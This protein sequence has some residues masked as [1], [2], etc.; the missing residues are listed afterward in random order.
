MATN[1]IGLL[2]SGCFGCTLLA[3]LP[4]CLS[5]RF[6]FT[7][8]RGL[9]LVCNDIIY[10]YR[11]GRDGLS[12]ESNLSAPGMKHETSIIHPP[13]KC[14]C[15]PA[16]GIIGFPLSSSQL[17]HTPVAFPALPVYPFAIIFPSP[18][19]RMTSLSTT[20]LESNTFSSTKNNYIYSFYQTTTM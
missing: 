3:L 2:Q 9:V 5:P 1:I 10:L 14:S 18:F 13:R 20:A 19:L 7:R 15:F 6:L 16:K 11:W 12:V 17:V 4:W 8:I